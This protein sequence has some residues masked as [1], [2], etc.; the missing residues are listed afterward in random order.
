MSPGAR[1]ALR[2]LAIV[3]GCSSCSSRRCVR[4]S[5]DSVRGR[6]LAA[7]ESALHRKVEAAASGCGSS[8]WAR[9]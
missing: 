4:V 6:V 7:A 1:R 3:A 8:R 2:I 9:A 5:F